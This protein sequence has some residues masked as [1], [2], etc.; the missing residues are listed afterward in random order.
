MKKN[1]LTID[2]LPPEGESPI[3]RIGVFA[4]EIAEMEDTLQGMRS[5][6]ENAKITIEL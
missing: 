3:Q 4:A 6:L 5:R 1:C 2:N